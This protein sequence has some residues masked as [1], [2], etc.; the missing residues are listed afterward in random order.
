[1]FNVAL[2]FSNNISSGPSQ[3]Q[4]DA[5]AAAGLNCQLEY[6]NSTTVKFSSKSGATISVITP[7]LKTI[8]ITTSGATATVSGSTSTLYYV[9][10]ASTGLS[11]STSA[12]DTNYTNMKT[13]SGNKI[14][15]GYMGCS[16]SN[17]IAGTHNV[18]SYW[19]EPQRS[20]TQSTTTF[21]SAQ[22][23]ALN[24]FV[25]P[26]TKTATASWSGTYTGYSYLSY[27]GTVNS[28]SQ[29]LTAPGSTSWLAFG[30]DMP[31]GSSSPPIYVG[32]E[33][34]QTMSISSTSF[35]N[36]AFNTNIYVSAS[37]AFQNL[38]YA[39]A[40]WAAKG[41]IR[42]ATSGTITLTRPGS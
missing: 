8:D 12:T 16:A 22:S 10:L 24:G 32:G 3:A 7:D 34:R 6:V 42:T 23:I 25:V 38:S 29:T 17:A 18:F 40:N 14:L 41:H 9:Y 26:P 33:R 4:F 11:F 19:N 1:M 36:G 27:N 37:E 5:Q 13:L 30:A 39:A 15:L 21:T 35:N 31:N 2:A 20:W 28:D